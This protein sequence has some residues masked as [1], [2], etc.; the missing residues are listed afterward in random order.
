MHPFSVALPIP[1]ALPH[2]WIDNDYLA[3]ATSSYQMTL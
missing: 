2:L 1:F 3:L